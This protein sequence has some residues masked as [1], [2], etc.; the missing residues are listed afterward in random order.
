MGTRSTGLIWLSITLCPAVT[1][2]NAP[3]LPVRIGTA[4]SVSG[5]CA[6]AAMESRR[7]RPRRTVPCRRRDAVFLHR[8][9]TTEPQLGECND[10][11][12]PAE[13]GERHRGN[14]RARGCGNRWER[15]FCFV[16]SP[17]PRPPV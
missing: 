16:V 10:F 13:E 4:F 6:P 9:D 7:H 11:L 5:V 2:L 15:Q 8:Y 1:K 12:S 3:A 14:F 17:I